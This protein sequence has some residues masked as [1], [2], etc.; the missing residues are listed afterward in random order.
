MSLN[1]TTGIIPFSELFER[2]MTLAKIDSFNNEDYAKG[3]INDAYTRALPN[4]NDWNVITKDAFL[5]MSASVN[6]GTVA[7]TAGTTT[8]TGSGTAWTTAMT[9]ANGWRIKFAG[10]NQVYEFTASGAGAATI[11][12]ALEGETNLVAQGYNLFRDEYSLPSDFDRFLK[13]GS[14]YVFQGG[15]RYNTI[16][17][18]PRD[19]FREQFF[20][21]PLDPIFRAMLTRVDTN[22]NRM[23]RLNPPP[24]TAKVY[25]IDYIPKIAPMREY[26]TGTASVNTGSPVVTGSGTLFLAN[27]V[28]GSY[29]RVD[30]V[31]QGDSS[32]WYQILSVDSNT[33]I[34]LT[35]NYEDAIES[36]IDYTVS[37]APSAFPSEF[38]EFIL[39]EAVSVAVASAD[40]PNTEAMIARRSDVLNRLNK[41]YK[42]RRTNS[43]YGVDDGGYR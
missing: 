32:K 22:G 15:R 14:I 23:V 10:L 42:S 19:Q 41:N 25:P 43:Q 20:P 26:T 2:L 31:G 8:V 37:S 34:T 21:E 33:Q 30:T 16:A 29:F 12:P 3:L 13:N 1:L 28:A 9:Y 27:C 11:N 36:G 40:D 39:M 18:I 5:R 35:S 6:A 38:H 17:E 24:K 7:C 4:L